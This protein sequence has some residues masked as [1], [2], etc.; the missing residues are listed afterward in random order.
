MKGAISMHDRLA[1]PSKVTK[2]R[3]SLASILVRILL[4]SSVAIS[5]SAQEPTRISVKPVHPKQA[6]RPRKATLPEIYEMFFTF[7]AHVE[8][9][10]EADIKRGR[11]MA[12]YRAHLQK[13]S[14]LSASEY[15]NVLESA[16]QFAAVDAETQKQF[17]ELVKQAKAANSGAASRTGL[18]AAN[19]TQMA[20]LAAQRTTSL[21]TEI[22]NVR[23]ALGVERADAF[24]TYLRTKYVERQI[25][26]KAPAKKGS[27]AQAGKPGL[28]P[29]DV[30]FSSGDSCDDFDLDDGGEWSVCA[31]AQISYLG[32]PES[33]L[34]EAYASM[35]W[36]V[37]DSNGW[38]I[39]DYSVEG[40]FFVDGVEHDNLDCEE[41]AQSCSSDVQLTS[42]SGTSY[43]WNS[44]GY[45]SLDYDDECDGY[46]SSDEEPY[47]SDDASVIIYYPDIN[48]VS[49]DSFN[50]KS[51]G[52]FSIDG[53]YLMSAFENPPT[54]TVN[55]QSA[56]FSTFDVTP[57]GSYPDGDIAV[58]YTVVD[59]APPGTYT[60]TV[61][62]GFGSD[63]DNIVIN[64][65][66][67]I[68]GIAVNGVANAALQADTSQTVTLTGNNFGSNAP[69]ITAF[70]DSEYIAIGAISAHSATSVTFSVTTAALAPSSS[71]DFQ[72]QATNGNAT[73]PAVAVDP[74]E[75]TPPL[76]LDGVAAD[77]DS[78]AGDN[79]GQGSASAQKVVVGQL[80][81]FTACSPTASITFGFLANASW[82]PPV[83][84][85]PTPPAVNSPAVSG[86][87]LAN[88]QPNPAWKNAA[89]QS[90]SVP[91][92]ATA[93]PVLF[94]NCA[95]LSNF[96]DFGPFY[97]VLP[98]TYNFTFT[99]D[100]NNGTPSQSATVQYIVGAPGQTGG[101]SFD[102]TT[103]GTVQIFA[104]GQLPNT[105]N[106]ASLLASGN[107]A[108]DP[109]IVFNAQG[110]AVS[111]A[112]VPGAYQWVQILTYVNIQALPNP[113]CAACLFQNELDNMYPYFVAA[114]PALNPLATGDNPAAG[115]VF[116][117][118]NGTVIPTYEIKDYFAA[119][120]S[121]M[122]D[123]ALDAFG[124]S[125]VVQGNPYG[126]AASSTWT[127]VNN[128]TVVTT[129][130]SSCAG[131][132]PVP[133]QSLSWGFC[134]D[135]INTL[136]TQPN[137]LGGQLPPNTWILNCSA[138][139]ANTLVPVFTDSV[140]SSSYPVWVAFMGNTG[141]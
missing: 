137:S 82:T 35:S 20:S 110:F 19:K 127:T 44:T 104:P 33:D 77:Y 140:G 36:S 62:N 49:P 39:T 28:S 118:A 13:A 43:D 132:I 24:E 108:N 31:D 6:G 91:M 4:L 106:T 50:Q 100:L 27:T 105:S 14:G 122:W 115:L 121:L 119:N 85:F 71:A 129:T 117:Q 97:F 124:N 22:A 41:D 68:T 55:D 139:G 78:C 120:M 57:P 47:T 48:A 92:T 74:W 125:T 59:T 37:D 7:A 3:S 5:V 30:T 128:A 18:T 56:L 11:H 32:S 52:A 73:S 111:P 21:T 64:V 95:T 60:L 134:G 66:P 81:Q 51:S 17:S 72:L 114:S 15:A 83:G 75:A 133:L 86:Y 136:Q 89:G 141:N 113:N 107:K 53:Q 88:Y 40:D 112:G 1:M 116:T 8:A 98:G 42:P 138:S 131:S 102:Y 63:T 135:A 46:C 90:I 10:A 67:D 61:N 109:G 54:V 69:V 2:R 38:E 29:Q 126:C 79:I 93:T 130:P 76:V 80:I 12:F 65:P 96:C 9:R 84:F 94:P 25:G 26:P 23:Q 99:Y 58:D 101:L 34:V 103:I 45:A 123:P 87:T 70:A 16:K